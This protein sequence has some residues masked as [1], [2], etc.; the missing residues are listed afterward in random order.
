MEDK[1]LKADLPVPG[2]VSFR[3]GKEG[4]P[5]FRKKDRG[6]KPPDVILYF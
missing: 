3:M 5:V 2:E 4:S 6:Q 1:I